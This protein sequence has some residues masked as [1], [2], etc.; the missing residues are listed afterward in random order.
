[1]AQSSENILLAQSQFSYPS[2]YR[3]ETCSLYFASFSRT[4]VSPLY[5]LPFIPNI[6]T[7]I[8][9]SFFKQSRRKK[10]VEQKD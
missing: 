1:M 6:R 4:R 2:V 7:I 10:M 5:K 8:N 3:I 9:K